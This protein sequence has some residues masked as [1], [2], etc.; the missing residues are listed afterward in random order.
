MCMHC[1]QIRLDLAE[2]NADIVCKVE[3]VWCFVFK[4]V[5]ARCDLKLLET[6]QLNIEATIC[7]TK[8]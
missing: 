2:G 5:A 8:S 3:R 4:K 7:A 6:N 1:L